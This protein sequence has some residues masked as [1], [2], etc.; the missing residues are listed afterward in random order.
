[1]F[2]IILLILI[3]LFLLGVTLLIAV[4]G[5]WFIKKNTAAAE[6]F[7]GKYQLSVEQ[8]KNRWFGYPK[9]FGEYN[10]H[11]L[12]IVT[13][14]NRSYDM[15]DLLTE[16][17][18]DTADCGDFA[19]AVFENRFLSR[20]QPAF[21]PFEEAKTGC[22]DFDQKFTVKTNDIG[23]VKSIMN[24]AIRSRMT[25]LIGIQAF[26]NLSFDGTTLIC[27]RQGTMVSDV[28]TVSLDQMLPVMA[29]IADEL[30]QYAVTEPDQMTEN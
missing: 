18:M 12:R 5:K 24:E 2:E 3:I 6:A 11:E 14:Q 10:G 26:F 28:V 8:P 22:A 9:I 7:A 25:G 19:F 29:Q 23:K 15:H 17:R 4:Y 13:F 27:R 1:M 16:L 21:R 30:K 20:L